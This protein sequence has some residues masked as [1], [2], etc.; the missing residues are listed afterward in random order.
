MTVANGGYTAVSRLYRFRDAGQHAP[1]HAGPG[2]G[3]WTPPPADPVTRIL[4]DWAAQHRYGNLI[5]APV[6]RTR[7]LEQ[8]RRSGR[9][10]RA[11]RNPS[12][13]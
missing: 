8:T 5:T 10:A 3:L 7:P 9:R 4:R 11:L 13:H 1:Q 2:H 6:H 12:A